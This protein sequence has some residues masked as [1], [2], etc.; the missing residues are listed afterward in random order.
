VAAVVVV[1]IVTVAA[2]LP[3]PQLALAVAGTLTVVTSWQLVPDSVWPEGQANCLDAAIVSTLV[4]LVPERVKPLS[5]VCPEVV[6]ATEV[7]LLWVHTEPC[8]AKPVGHVEPV[9][10]P[11]DVMPPTVMQFEPLSTDP[12][13]HV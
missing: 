11:G 2:R 8:R 10:V 5:Q 3:L 12:E 6:A 7:V 4:Q 13:A 9:S 1:E